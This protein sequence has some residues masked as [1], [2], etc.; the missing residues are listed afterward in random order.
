MQTSGIYIIVG[1]YH[2][3]QDIQDRSEI[4]LPKP[5]R[6]LLTL[7][8]SFSWM[9]SRY[10]CTLTSNSPEEKEG[11]V[12]HWIAVHQLLLPTALYLSGPACGAPSPG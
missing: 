8:C 7:R 2:C 9:D 1:F 11:E 10:S 6:N 4:I 5:L 12:N 3:G